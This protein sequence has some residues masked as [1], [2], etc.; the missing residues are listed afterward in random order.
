MFVSI[1]FV[2]QQTHGISWLM[3]A[4]EYVMYEENSLLNIKTD[5]NFQSNK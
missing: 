4:V 2:Y 3:E 5:A 1:H